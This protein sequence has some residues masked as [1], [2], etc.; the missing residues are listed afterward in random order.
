MSCTARLPQTA[1]YMALHQTADSLEGKSQEKDRDK[2][3]GGKKKEKEK[4]TNSRESRRKLHT[5]LCDA[6][7]MKHCFPHKMIMLLNEIWQYSCKRFNPRI[8]SCHAN[9][10]HVSRMTQSWGAGI[11]LIHHF[12]A[13]PA[14]Y[15]IIL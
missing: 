7:G 12:T 1:S 5:K 2:A 13:P 15:G 3:C 14:S 10:A 9:G 11:L 8:S 4:K 6:S